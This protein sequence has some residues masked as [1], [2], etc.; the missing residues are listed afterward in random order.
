MIKQVFL[1]DSHE[2]GYTKDYLLI[3]GINP[4]QKN[5]LQRDYQHEINVLISSFIIVL[6]LRLCHLE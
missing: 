3:L 2:E 6:K 1:L 4:G 5:S